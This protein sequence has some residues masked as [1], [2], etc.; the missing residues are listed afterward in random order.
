MEGFEGYQLDGHSALQEAH[1]QSC[2]INGTSPA[3][4]STVIELSRKDASVIPAIGI[5]PQFI[6]NAPESWKTLFL[7]FL[8][9]NDRCVIGEVGLDR[10][11]KHLSF[12]QQLD[13]FSWQLRQACSRNLPISIHCLKA[14]GPMVDTLRTQ[15]L[16]DRGL[17][18]HAYN[19]PVELISELSEMRTYFSFSAQQLDYESP[20]IISRIRAVPLNYLLIETDDCYTGNP[21]ILYYCYKKV[22]SILGL[23]IE[24]LAERI[25]E[26]FRAY[27]LAR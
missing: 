26:N 18:L 17:H 20:K 8:D 21:D 23:S 1:I 7:K 15:S 24:Y 16:P 3:D 22:A 9:E 14:I 2:V 6:L 12:E 5:H 4:W 27:F 13:A 10:R 25:E 19:G 11:D